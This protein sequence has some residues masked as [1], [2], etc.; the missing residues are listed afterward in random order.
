MNAPLTSIRLIEPEDAEALAGHLGRDAEAFA[1]WDP[2]REPEFYTAAGQ[3]R[4]IEE[5]RKRHEAGEVWPG[6]ILA[7]DA[8]IGQLTVQNILRRA[9]Q[10]AELG[11]WIGYPHQGQGHA[12]RAVSLAVQLMTA[13]L[14][15]HRGE[16]FTDVD[17]L[18]SQQV[19][20]NNGF[21]PCGVLRS[22]MFTAGM[23]R[24]SILWERLLDQ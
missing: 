6:V 2:E 13:Q 5:S 16:A 15:L 1:R 4:R 22:R 20:R 24:D 7:G 18:A 10:K 12:T 23:W 21:T 9:W 8:V 14:E 3:R 17:N 19:L 11:Y